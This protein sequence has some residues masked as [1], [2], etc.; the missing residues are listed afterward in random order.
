MPDPPLVLGVPGQLLSKEALLI[1]QT[2]KGGV[3]TVT[4]TDDRPGEVHYESMSIIGP[5]VKIDQLHN[6][7][8]VEGRRRVSESCDRDPSKPAAAATFCALGSK[9]ADACKVDGRH[10]RKG[11]RHAQRA[12]RGSGS[13]QKGANH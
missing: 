9:L 3:M 11:L 4:G 8:T 10:N 1:E 13:I 7:A 12:R 6:V 2:P 5:L